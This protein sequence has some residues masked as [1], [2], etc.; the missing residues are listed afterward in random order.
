MPAEDILLHGATVI[1]G[2]GTPPRPR[3]SVLIEGSRIVAVGAEADALAADSPG[4]ARVDLSGHTIVP[5]LID[6]HVHSTF[7]SE[8][9]VYLSHGV[10]SVR[11]AGIDLPAWRAIR[12]R[13]AADDP[14][15]P[16]QLNLGPM[17]DREPASWPQWSTPIG[18][19]EEAARTAAR[20]L[21]DEHTDGLICVQQLRPADLRAVVETA[22]ERNKPVAGQLWWTSAVEAA[23]IG[24]DQLD[25][26]A[27]VAAS[28]EITG[29][30]LF[31]YRSVSERMTLLTNLW[32]TVDWNETDRMIEAMVRAGVAYGPTFVVFE[33][34]AGIHPETLDG[35]PAFDTAYGEAETAAWAAF[36]HHIVNVWTKA[37]R[38]R[39]RQSIEVR[40]EWIRRFH[41]AGGRL[42]VGTDMQYGGIAIHRELAILTEV[43]LTNV[44]AIAAAT[45]EAARV[46]RRDDLG[47]IAGGRFADLVVVDG[48]PSV[49]LSA[50]RRIRAVIRGG[51]VVH[52]AL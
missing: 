19:P 12:D 44:Q 49:D 40:L 5:G 20:L 31:S 4:L 13:V 23:E 35:D 29:D 7:P 36:L 14:P 52:G 2:T 10:T 8:Q 26:T 48:D 30:R 34:Q 45:G 22:H 21:D 43:G 24:I 32:L 50:L 11:Y 33:Q 15:G 3:I 16:R 38:A 1:D 37:D 25:N 18:S 39:F 6:L 47:V 42:V 41:A 9:G 27:R 28:S 51:Q 46:M 17:I